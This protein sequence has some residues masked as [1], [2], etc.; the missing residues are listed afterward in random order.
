MVGF[1]WNFT[2][3]VDSNGALVVYHHPGMFNNDW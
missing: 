3:F 2:N 1:R